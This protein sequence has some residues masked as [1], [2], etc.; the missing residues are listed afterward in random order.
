VIIGLLFGQLPLREVLGGGHIL[1]N[2]F[3]QVVHATVFM[4]GISYALRWDRHVRM[5]VFYRHFSARTKA[6]VNLGGALLLILPWC[7]AM[8]GFGW[9]I[10]WRSVAVLERF[11]DTFSPGY[12]VFKLAL[13]I[14]ICLVSLQ[15]IA[16]AVRSLATLTSHT[17]ESSRP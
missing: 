5:D 16:L 8:I 15:A 11:P 2:D 3:G 17:S 10:M 1:A 9:S 13:I 12:F 7:A 14:A 4:I 6:W